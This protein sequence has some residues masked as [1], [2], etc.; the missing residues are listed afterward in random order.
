MHQSRSVASRFSSYPFC[1]QV[2][3]AALEIGFLSGMYGEVSTAVFWL[4]NKIGIHSEA[5]S[6]W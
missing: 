4:L 5:R 1:T 6:H 2:A 3:Y